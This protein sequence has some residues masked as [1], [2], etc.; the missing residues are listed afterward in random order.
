MCIILC[1]VLFLCCRWALLSAL[2]PVD[3]NAQRVTKYQQYADELDFSGVEFPATL[4]DV[5]RVCL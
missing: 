1:V 2:H 5:D 3:C 4:C